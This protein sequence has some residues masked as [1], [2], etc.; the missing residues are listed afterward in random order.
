L[1]MRETDDDGMDMPLKAQ[2]HEGTIRDAIERVVG[3]ELEGWEFAVPE[4]TAIKINTANARHTCLVVGVVG[5]VL[6]VAFAMILSFV[7]GAQA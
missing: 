7:A 2:R 5:I 1:P 6:L 4:E 3:R